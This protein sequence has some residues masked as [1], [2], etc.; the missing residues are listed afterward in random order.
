MKNGTIQTIGCVFNSSGYLNF[1]L[2][3]KYNQG[4]Y[5][6]PNVVIEF[7]DGSKEPLPAYCKGKYK[8]DGR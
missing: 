6:F 7:N 3:D 1:V 4:F 2:Y 5:K 8:S